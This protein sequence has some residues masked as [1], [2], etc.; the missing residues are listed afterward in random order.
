MN[1]DLDDLI[2]TPEPDPEPK[3]PR[4][5]DYVAKAEDRR[6]PDAPALQALLRPVSITFMSEALKMDRKTVTR[7]LADLTPLG[8]HRG[9]SPLYD[10]RQALPY[11]IT[12]KFDVEK[13]LEKIGTESLPP[14]LQKDVWDAKLKAQKWRQNAGELWQTEDVLE[15][16][17]EAFSRL[18]TSTQLWIDQIADNHA[19][20]TSA[21]VELADLV[22]GLQTDLHRTLVE[23]PKER[24][25]YS[26]LGEE[27]EQ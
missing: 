9:N 27:D 21:Q 12:P 10:F 14:S 18:R 19:L 23:M 26:Q 22:N 24:A 15:V 5:R 16:L 25:T 17:G 7:R 2:G 20:P 3:K 11:L 1:D 4:R 6:K 8:Y 13:A